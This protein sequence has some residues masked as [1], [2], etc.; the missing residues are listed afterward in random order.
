MLSIRGDETPRGVGK[1]GVLGQVVALEAV[2]K[3]EERRV[4]LMIF[5][6]E[7]IQR[8]DL[9]KLGSGERANGGKRCWPRQQDWK[10]REET[11]RILETRRFRVYNVAVAA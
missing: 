5:V 6:C 11:R 4:A 7:C 1:E 2:E 3:G 10:R 8:M 9:C